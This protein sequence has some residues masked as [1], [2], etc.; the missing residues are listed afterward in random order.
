[1]ELDRL[2]DK[3][4]DQPP[5]MPR[6]RLIS[7][8]RLLEA[9]ANMSGGRASIPEL[10]DALSTAY[11]GDT[12]ML[13]DGRGYG[14]ADAMDGYLSDEYGG[15]NM[16]VDAICELFNCRF[17]DRPD[18]CIGDM[19]PELLMVLREDAVSIAQN[20]WELFLPNDKKVADDFRALVETTA[21][22]ESGGQVNGVGA[23]AEQADWPWGSHE[24]KLLRD[25][26]AATQRWWVNVDPMD[27][28]TAHTNEEVANWLVKER[29]VSP[30]MAQ[31]MATI[32]RADGLPP[33]PRT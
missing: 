32:L 21:K 15:Y 20:L 6:T 19:P 30:R 14:L 4:R 16:R 5:A 1:M 8:V 28:T 12:M 23:G 22:S 9:L 13:Y 18:A 31:S 24:T 25:L 10:V 29:G 11:D 26:A 3:R 17:W 2:L 33:G 27:N 7:L